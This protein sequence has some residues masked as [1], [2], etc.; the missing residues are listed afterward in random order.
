MRDLAGK[1]MFKHCGMSHLHVLIL[2][3]FIGLLCTYEI[4]SADIKHIL[5]HVC[6]L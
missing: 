4:K 2:T 6:Y 1:T 3:L 5:K